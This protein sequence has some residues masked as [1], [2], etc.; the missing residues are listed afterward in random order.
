MTDLLAISSQAIDSGRVDQPVNRVNHELSEIAPDV[1]MVE[2]FSHAIVFRTS[3]GLLVFDTSGVQGGGQV[4]QQIKA[5]SD[6]PVHSIVYTHG[7]LDHV[8]G[9]GAFAADARDR[10]RP[11]PQFV[12]HRN[13]AP[14][15]ARYDRTA[16]YNLAIN[17]RQF[18]GRNFTIGGAG[19]FLPEDVVWPDVSYQD[20]MMLKV[21]DLEVELHHAKGET[22]DHTWSYLPA[23]QA[24]CAGDFFIWNFPNAGNPQ[25]VQR[26]PLEWAAAMRAMAA[27]DAE[28]FLP[29]HGLPIAGRA[30]IRTVLGNV[31]TAL[32][33]LVRD[34]LAMMNDGARLDD[35]LHSVKVPKETL[36]LPYLRP[37]YDEPEFVVRNVWRLYGGW[38]DGNPA[39]LKPA[40]HDAL[41]GEIAALAGGAKALAARAQVLSAAGE[42]RLACH[43][44]EYAVAAE[45][46]DKSLHDARAHVY[47]QRRGSETS[48]MAKGIFGTAANESRAIAGGD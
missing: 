44:V 15:F 36:E 6:A 45:P 48:L 40:H 9:S 39:H 7:H 21:G 19:S 30:R 10:G 14:R 46:G 8:G 23:Q 33:N 38:Y 20:Q 11:R 18:S 32:E 5:W 34:A 2:A 43:L 1:A 13:V 28:L 35:I 26:F 24:I 41:A 3:A 22:D 37:L 12:G 25:K 4:V 42:H 31:A 29:A 27:K 16:G 47:Q 17:A